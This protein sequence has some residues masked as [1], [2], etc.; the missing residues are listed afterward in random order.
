MTDTTVIGLEA[1]EAQSLASGAIGNAVLAVELA[2]NTGQW[3]NAKRFIQQVAGG[4]IDAGSHSG[5]FYGAPAIAFLLYLT[6]TGR[7]ERARQQLQ[8]H[9]S[10][11]IHTRLLAADERIRQ[12]R[13]TAFAEYDLLYGLTGLG[14]LLL[15]HAPGCDELGDILAYT[16]RLVQPQHNDGVELPGWWVEHDPDSLI[17]TPG[18][19]ANLGMAHGAGGLL[20][21]LSLA[22]Q[23]GIQVDGQ[24]EAIGWLCAWFDRWQYD[25][26]A[27]TFWPQWLTA[28]DV[29]SGRVNHVR[30]SRPSWCYGAVG[31]AR[32]QQLAALATGDPGRQS[33]AERVLAGCLDP[34]EVARLTEAGICHGRAG[35][36]Q[37]AYRAAQDAADPRIAERLP[38]L[39][40]LVSPETGAN[41][42]LLNGSEGVGL[43]QHSIGTGEPPRTR[44]DTCLL[45][46]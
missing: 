6:G 37:T 11:L 10:R 14:A 35:L 15:E 38:Y 3:A 18:G 7:Y 39:A 41:T 43:V 5:L 22:A 27:G 44:W 12:R 40:A 2:H 20:A 16:V 28:D 9:V 46:V 19:H 30:Q 29:R 13:A 4:P 45:I 23:R 25:T 31:I 26:A 8:R 1:A 34:A 36:Y 33:R 42:G 17:P 21:L 24:Y 32:A